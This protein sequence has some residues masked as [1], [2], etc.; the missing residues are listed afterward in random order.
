MAEQF[1][2]CE[3]LKAD[4]DLGI[5]YGMPIVCEKDGQPH[6]DTQGDVIPER[7]MVEKAA[8]FAAGPRHSGDSHVE[9]QDGTVLFIFP[10]TKSVADALE[11][12]TP[13]YGL[14]V[15]AKPSAEVYERVKKGELNEFSIG[16]S[17]FDADTAYEWIDVEDE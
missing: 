8:A 14:L 4:D 12:K 10:L 1:T 13:R 16:G 11:I 5:V 3:I 15:G 17:R 2:R 6:R 9:T 7:A